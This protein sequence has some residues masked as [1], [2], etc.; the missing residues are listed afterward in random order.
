MGK[1]IH[2]PGDI[3]PQSGIYTIDHGPHRLIHE[4]T[5]IKGTRF[6]RC[7]QCK[8]KV[9]F[10]LLKAVQDKRS[11]LPFRSTGILEEYPEEEWAPPL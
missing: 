10:I 1:A 5:L 6:P 3:V 11:I 7:K 8:N 4:A 9:R 2:K